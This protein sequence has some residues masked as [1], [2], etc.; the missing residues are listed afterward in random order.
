MD[1]TF[2]WDE[3]KARE[4]LH[5]HHISFQEAKT[6]FDDPFLWTFPD[7]DHSDDEERYV[8]IGNSAKHRTL[9]VVHT[10][11]KTNVRIISCR[12]ATPFERK[13]YAKRSL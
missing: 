8:N 7:P 2:E 4:N 12:K 13:A 5:K 6:V 10:D 11:R 9:V 3:E 1:L